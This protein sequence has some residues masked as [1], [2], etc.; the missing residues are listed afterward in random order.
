LEEVIGHYKAGGRTIKKG[1]LAGVG[2][3]NPL[4]SKV[5]S[6]FKLTV[7][8]PRDVLNFLKNLTEVWSISNPALR[9]PSLPLL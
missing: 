8:K 4:K 3:K 1:K 7:K 6:A 9:I 5:V 2:S